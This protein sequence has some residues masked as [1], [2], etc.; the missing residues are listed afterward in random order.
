[1]EDAP[2]SSRLTRNSNSN[3]DSSVNAS[4]ERF[5]IRAQTTSPVQLE[6]SYA[7]TFSS[8]AEEISYNT[9]PP[10]AFHEAPPTTTPLS[11]SQTT[12][13]IPVSVIQSSSSHVHSSPS[14]GQV[15]RRHRRRHNIS[16]PEARTSTLDSAL[17]GRASLPP[18]MLSSTQPI[19]MLSRPS[20][21]LTEHAQNNGH[22]LSRTEH[23]QNSGH[24]FSLTEHALNNGHEHAL[25]VRTTIVNEEAVVLNDSSVQG[26]PHGHVAIQV[27]L[28]MPFSRYTSGRPGLHT[29]L[30]SSRN[31]DAQRERERLEHSTSFIAARSRDRPTTTRRRG[32]RRN[33]NVDQMEEQVE[34]ASSSSNQHHTRDRSPH[35][36]P[37]P[38]SLAGRPSRQRRA[39]PS[40]HSTSSVPLSSVSLP[41]VRSVSHLPPP[42]ALGFQIVPQLPVGVAS[43]SDGGMAY[44]HSAWRPLHRQGGM[45]INLSSPLSQSRLEHGLT[46]NSS[47]P[48]FHDVIPS[49]V[50]IPAS[51]SSSSFHRPSS[52]RGTTSA[53]IESGSHSSG[54]PGSMP[55]LI[56][57]YEGGSTS[58]EES[59]VERGIHTVSHDHNDVIIVDSSDSE[60]RL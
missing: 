35:G 48:I 28:A 44:D 51:H 19:A 8:T 15:N 22:I 17:S 6:H 24:A 34:E 32:R 3:G 2:Q 36:V 58:G 11:S 53:G 7:L 9:N 50:N 43:D 45:S 4:G 12:S 5:D 39:G 26:L 14:R 49:Y 37:L 30:V 1:M 40:S 27:P 42:H 23:A 18:Y 13:S 38:F 10:A 60:V 25:D 31:E 54:L 57:V 56:H 46:R 52:I 59:A 33:R 20:L 55:P 29:E 41:S 21:S 16:G 47:Q